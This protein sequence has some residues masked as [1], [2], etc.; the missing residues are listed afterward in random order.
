MSLKQLGQAEVLDQQIKLL[1]KG[2]KTRPLSSTLRKTQVREVMRVFLRG[3]NKNTIQWPRVRPAFL[4]VDI[5]ARGA[6]FTTSVFST[7][8]LPKLS[9]QCNTANLHRTRHRGGITQQ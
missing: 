9:F 5:L 6:L 7:T 3:E 1:G 4:T 2:V 8:F